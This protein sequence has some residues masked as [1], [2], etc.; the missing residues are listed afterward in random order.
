MKKFSLLTFA[1]MTILFVFFEIAFANLHDGL[2]AYY[3]FN[4]NA[5][6]ISGNNNHGTINGATPAKD[7]FG[8]P[9]SS[10]DFQGKQNVLISNFPTLSS[11]TFAGWINWDKINGWE[12]F[13]DNTTTGVRFELLTN[14]LSL[15]DHF[16]SILSVKTSTWYHLTVTY[17]RNTKI[18]RHYL[19]GQKV[20]EINAS[21]T[22]V[23]GTIYL[24]EG[25]TGGH[26]FLTGKIDDIYIYNRSL[27]NSEIRELYNLNDSDGLV[28]Y[29]PFNGNANDESGN[30]NH[31]IVNGATLTKD[32]L[33][34]PDSS[35]EF[36]GDENIL[37]T[38]FPSTSSFTFA[39]WVYWHK[40]DGLGAI[41]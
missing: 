26:E 16:S 37:I 30:D 8:N 17:D 33:G 5:N 9:N 10:Y 31:G 3:P 34:N 24:G 6:D 21:M 4:G 22:N 14:R 36:K 25:P 29:Y 7:R 1:V 41:Y 27:S 11:F 28:A 40:I 18:I 20:G 12:P 32:R 13:I 35:Y 38:N 2:M 39:G 23:S 19:N 15:S